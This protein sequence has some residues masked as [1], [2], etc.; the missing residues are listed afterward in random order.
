MCLS[1]I[2]NFPIIE[3]SPHVTFSVRKTRTPH[4]FNPVLIKVTP[5]PE[6]NFLSTAV[7]SL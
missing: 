6:T 7:N 4:T 5:T 1:E 2:P 3:I